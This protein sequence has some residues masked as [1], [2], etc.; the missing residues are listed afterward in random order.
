MIGPSR[1]GLAERDG[2]EVEVG[3]GEVDAVLHLL[4]AAHRA[5]LSGHRWFY[6]RGQGEMNALPSWGGGV[7]RYGA[8]G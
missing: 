8:R 2:H 5:I 3:F 7:V 6:G 4:F 1:E